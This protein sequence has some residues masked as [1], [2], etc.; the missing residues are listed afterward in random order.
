MGDLDGEV[1]LIT[2]AARGIGRIYALHLARAGAAIGVVDLSLTSFEEH[3]EEAAA[4]TGA[5]V[6]EELQSLGVS[7]AGAEADVTEA[8]AMAAAVEKI[9]AELGDP[10]IA[11][12]NA[13]GGRF[14][15]PEELEQQASSMDLDAL[16]GRFDANFF[17][18]V[19]TV[20]AVAP[21]MKRQRKGRIVTVGS[22]SGLMARPDGSHADYG[23]S[24]AAIVHYT[25]A[26]AAELGPFNINVNCIAPGLITTPRIAEKYG[27]S[28]EL[29]D[30]IALRRLGT[31][32]EC[33]TAVEFLVSPASS[34][35]TGSVLE[36][37]GGTRV[38]R[39][40]PH[41][42]PWWDTTDES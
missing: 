23:A 22:V 11:I 4:M 39:W 33:A 34:Y 8:D 19:H 1:A 41:P 28:P 26:L 40:G 9:A 21:G 6:L 5:T 36:V 42:T 30:N 15:A 37:H 27:D 20:R 13:G 29:Y 24:K 32:E 38:P 7:A 3:E 25:K 31:P 12:C 17:G 35:I 16:R 10:T 14:G 2:G 18:T